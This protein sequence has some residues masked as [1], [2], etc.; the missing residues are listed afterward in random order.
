MKLEQFSVQESPAGSYD[1]EMRGTV[2]S[3]AEGLALAAMLGGGPLVNSATEAA[4]APAIAP[5]KPA[6]SAPIAAGS[7]VAPQSTTIAAHPAVAA[8][9]KSKGTTPTTHDT[10][11]GKVKVTQVKG[12]FKAQGMSD[13]NT[14]LLAGGDTEDEALANWLELMASEPAVAKPVTVVTAPP[15]PAAAAAAAPSADAPPAAPSADAPPAASAVDVPAE[16]AAATSFRHVMTW[17]VANVGSDAA[18]IAA[19]CEELRASV[20]AIA[21]LQGDISTRI[22][23]ALYALGGNSGAPA[24]T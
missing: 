21:R 22:E 19:K 15:L 24:T 12:G 14:G 3:L 17:M 10:A 11:A 18:A 1:V 16:L 2:S 8:M 13:P 23:R 9:R 4:F 5:D 20:P 7:T 6:T